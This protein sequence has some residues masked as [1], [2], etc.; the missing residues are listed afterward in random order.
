MT[1]AFAAKKDNNLVPDPSFEKK[2]AWAFTKLKEYES[3]KDKVKRGAYSFETISTSSRQYFR[4]AHVLDLEEGAT[5]LLSMDLEISGSGTIY[6]NYGEGLGVGKKM[7]KSKNENLSN[8]GLSVELTQFQKEGTLQCYFTVPEVSSK[9]RGTLSMAFGEY[10][11][12]FSMKNLKV[13]KVDEAPQAV[14][15]KGIYQWDEGE[16]MTNGKS[17]KK[18]VKKEKKNKKEKNTGK[19]VSI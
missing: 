19:V 17:K 18:K 8:L 2:G 6:M 10:L 3:L 9:F 12:K 14:G 1:S 5:Y 16:F 13:V 15:D 11:G 7:K 4:L